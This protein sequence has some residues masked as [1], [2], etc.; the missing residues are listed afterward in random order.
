MPV[1]QSIY[2]EL[3]DQNIEFILAAQDTGGKAAADKFYEDAKVTYTAIID[4]NHT[5]SSLYNFVNVP[6]G[7]WIDEEGKIV[8]INEGTYAAKHLGG[9]IGTDEYVP[10]IRDWVAKG[11]ASKFVWNAEKVAEKIKKRSPDH[12]K[13]EPAFKLGN[14]FH[15]L[16]NNDKALVYWAMA[17]E[18]NPDNINYMRQDLSF[19]EEGSSGATF[20]AKRE[21]FQSK[22]KAY[23]EDLELEAEAT[24]EKSQ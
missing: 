3:K 13:A 14:H 10:A 1:W 22:G 11:A 23:Y 17:R 5:I 24:T 15:T 6:S 16:G 2:D 20:R 12:E 8:R 4:V 7:A 19:T 9:R 18:L 21:E